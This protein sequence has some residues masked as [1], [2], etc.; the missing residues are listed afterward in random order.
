MDDDGSGNLVESEAEQSED[1]NQLFGGDDD[2]EEE[3]EDGEGMSHG[4]ENTHDTVCVT[5][6]IRGRVRTS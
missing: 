2:E 4:K 1:E 6:W 3:E 5:H